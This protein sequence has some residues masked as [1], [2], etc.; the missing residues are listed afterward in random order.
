MKKPIK[1]IKVQLNDRS[2]AR[3]YLHKIR[4]VHEVI[5]V[6]DPKDIKPAICKILAELELDARRGHVLLK[7]EKQLYVCE[8]NLNNRNVDYSK[9]PVAYHPY[10]NLLTD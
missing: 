10:Q 3:A 7:W 9:T 2:N 6:Q 4:D 1:L 8:R 5:T